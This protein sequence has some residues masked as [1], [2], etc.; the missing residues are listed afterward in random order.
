MTF[1][2]MAIS[3]G[4][5][6]GRVE[7]IES[8][9]GDWATRDVAEQLEK[10]R[11]AYRDEC[12]TRGGRELQALCEKEQAAKDAVEMALLAQRKIYELYDGKSAHMDDPSYIE[13]QAII[14]RYAG[15][16][17]NG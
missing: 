1:Y 9:N 3:Y 12:I 16:T 13:A 11:N 2:N 14:E 6:G 4:V 5:D 17:G 8:T 10:E 7:P 15:G